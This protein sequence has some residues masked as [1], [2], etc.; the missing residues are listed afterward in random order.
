MR[1]A[2]DR[3]DGSAVRATD[4]CSNFVTHGGTDGIPLA[5]SDFS[6]YHGANHLWP[7]SLSHDACSNLCSSI[8][9]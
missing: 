6:A 4:T 9:L 2:D 3:A 5:R 8:D 1:R 7:N